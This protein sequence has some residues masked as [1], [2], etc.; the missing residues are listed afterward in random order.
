M[1]K[2]KRLSK[3]MWI[4]F[5]LIGLAGQFAWAIENMYL[6]TYITYLN[7]TD[8]SGI[9]FNYSQ[10][11][12]ITTA[13]S[14]VI[15]TLTTLLMGGLTDKIGKRKLFIT[16]GY[17][18]WGVATASFGLC[19]VNSN[20]A[21]IPISMTAFS[22]AIMVIVI[23]G[24]MTFFGS[25]ANDAA[26]N[27]YVTT[28]TSDANRG[29]VEGVLSVLPLVAMLI[30][31]VGLNG[32]TTK[33]AGYRWDLFFY[34]VGGLVIL[35]GLTSIFLIPKEKD[36]HKSNEPYVKLMAEGFKPSVI[37]RNKK[38][39]IILLIYFIYGVACQIYFP[40][41]MVY[42][43]KTCA[44]ANSGGGFLTPF[45]IVMAVSLLLGSVAS[46]LLGFLS[47][48]FGKNKIIIP[49]FAILF[50]GLILLYFVPSTKNDLARTVF[51]SIAG[52][53][54]IF[55]YVGVPT[56]INSLVR[57]YVPKGKEGTF[58][59]V[60]M[61]FVVAAPMCIGP[62][63][64]DALNHAYGSTYEGEFGVTSIIPSEYGY[65]VAAAIL[66]LALIPIFYFLRLQKKE[67][68]KNEGLLYNDK[69]KYDV[70]Y[71]SVP[72]SQY[73]RPNFVRNSYLCLNGKWDVKITKEEELPASYDASIIVP[74]AVE[75]IPSGINHN[76][77][78]NEYIYYH[79]VITIDSSFNKG[80][81]FINFD[82]V[83]QEA[84]IY[85]NKKKVYNHVSGYEKFKIDVT[86]YFENN[87]LDLIVKVNDISDYSYHSRGKQ[88]LHPTGW[89]YSSSSGIYKPVW[90]EST[91]EEYID[92]VLF[93]P[94]S[95]LTGVKI[96]VRSSYDRKVDITIENKKY[97]VQTNKEQEL[98]IENPK[99]WSPSS[100][101]LYFVT[102]KMGQDE[103]TSYFGMRKIEIKEGKDGYKHVYLNN[104]LVIL[105]GLLDQGYFFLGN[106]TPM[107][108]SDFDEDI[109]RVKELGYNTL[110]KHIKI[111]CDLFYYTCDKYGILVIQDFPCGGKPYKF[112]HVVIPRFFNF[113]NHENKMTYKKMSRED[114]AGRKEF[115]RESEHYLEV[116]HNYP[117]IVVYTIFNE[118]WGEFNPS[119][120]YTK[121]KNIDPSRL[122]DTASGWYDSENSDFYSIHSYSFPGMKR[123]DKMGRRPYIL[124]E[125][126]GASLK[127]DKHFYFNKVY[128]HGIS[129]TK[130]NL[131]KRYEKLY[132]NVV[133]PQLK[134]GNLVGS[135][136]TGLTDCE[137][138]CNGI[139]TFDRQVLKLDK[140]FLLEINTEI[141]KL[142]E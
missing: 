122:Y 51:C 139:Y 98:L 14:A 49:A 67:N 24:I 97:T 44:V 8:P 17:L 9:G 64:G 22:A 90:L 26:F 30:I 136:Y 124:T 42:I 129:K 137:T 80:K 33:D 119:Y 19:N 13:V 123:K 96:L 62:F 95:S 138:E 23:D 72:L 6:N 82:G 86:P 70:N 125:I 40:Y 89:F 2:T 104:K 110:R 142:M 52:F 121:L 88:R 57:Q 127:I 116:L 48:K 34:I 107:K 126:G 58:M 10:L 114:E 47:D 61:I 18:V 133:I 41:L 78:I 130:E 100:P 111:E 93:T 32:L 71:S 120:F 65:L 94:N 99:L 77:E 63:I 56:V 66:L 29:K 16:I 35:V 68:T 4:V 3:R 73:P 128:G 59:G 118:G 106:L 115:E 53:I 140:S 81:V 27:S 55:G 113:M 15:A 69:V 28:S 91:P 74:Y 141:N 101:N 1:D 87:S 50:L 103:I 79:R 105:N 20:Y 92:S 83:D 85:I 46:V 11:I 134:N 45:A 109:K 132:R 75:S 12:A 60:R 38:L 21:I 43:E 112:F 117:S 5:I 31:F 131:T 39:Y 7:F 108:Y 84:T 54:M 25:A 37:K 102:L 36:E 135:I 76:L